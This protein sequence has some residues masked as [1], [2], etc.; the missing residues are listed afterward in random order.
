MYYN[1]SRR[2]GIM[3]LDRPDES[4][5]PVYKSTSKEKAK[6]ILKNAAP[7]AFA[8]VD[9]SYTATN[10]TT[11]PTLI[12]YVKRPERL[13]DAQHGYGAIAETRFVYHKTQGWITPQNTE[14]EKYIKEGQIKNYDLEDFQQLL[15]IDLPKRNFKHAV[16][17]AADNVA[18]EPNF[19]AFRIW[20]ELRDIVTKK[21]AFSFWSSK[22]QDQAKQK[23]S[24]I[25][26][27]NKP[28]KNDDAK[29]IAGK[30]A[31]IYKET[32]QVTG[33][34]KFQDSFQKEV[35]DFLQK[36]D[37]DLS[38]KTLNELYSPN[39]NNIKERKSQSKL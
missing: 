18:I 24:Q 28:S 38:A 35:S 17:P 13:D 29:E 1:D 8:L 11:V 16:V 22:D 6:D 33:K 2:G 21:T 4:K 10:K 9:N 23:I 31:T 37:P 26:I 20:V 25:L 27:D 3:S 34:L 30:I 15:L 14:L 32:Y 12:C 7:G 39:Q 36:A 19:P 5:W